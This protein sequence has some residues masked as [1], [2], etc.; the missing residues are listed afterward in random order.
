MEFSSRRDIWIGSV[1]WA[2]IGLFIWLLYKSLFVELDLLGLFF[3]IIFI[4]F[5]GWIWFHTKYI[6]SGD[7]LFIIFGPIKK[8]IPIHDIRSA[9][10][11]TNPISSPSLS[12]YKIE[13]NY[14]KYD[15]ISISPKRREDFLEHLLRKNP[16]I[17]RIEV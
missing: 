15:T 2:S 11:T 9:R 6:I 1:W 13:I 10:F 12:I 8:T 17:K 7:E 4:G 14:G 16:H 3:S 5:F